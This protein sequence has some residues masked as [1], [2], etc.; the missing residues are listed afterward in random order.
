MKK[1]VITEEIINDLPLLTEEEEK[2][3]CSHEEFVQTVLEGV[4][5]ALADLDEDGNL[6]K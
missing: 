3:C 2:K 4:K 5:K 1:K 6:I